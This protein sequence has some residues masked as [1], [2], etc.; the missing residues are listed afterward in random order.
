MVFIK[1]IYLRIF[2][3]EFL[4]PN[5][6][7]NFYKLT[8]RPGAGFFRYHGAGCDD[9]CLPSE[10]YFYKEILLIIRNFKFSLIFFCNPVNRIQ[11]NTRCFVFRGNEFSVAVYEGAL[12]G[13]TDLYGNQMRCCLSCF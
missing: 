5:F 4:K 1:P 8:A 12:I 9:F 2:R 3:N 11:A 10:Q 6:K 13:I 7:L